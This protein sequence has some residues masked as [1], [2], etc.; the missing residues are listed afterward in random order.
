[1]PAPYLS[2]DVAGGKP[3]GDA[4]ARQSDR[5]G[6]TGRG[7]PVAQRPA[8]RPGDPW[9]ESWDSWRLEDVELLPSGEDKV[10]GL[11]RM[12]VKG[13]GSGIELARDD[14]IL[15]EFAEGKIVRIGYYNDHA[16]AR[17]AAGLTE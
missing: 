4:S 15:A 9:N 17:E 14:A 10:L 1:M 12:I 8:H 7:H 11:F 5:R 16:Q 6:T 13:K 3:G 2:G